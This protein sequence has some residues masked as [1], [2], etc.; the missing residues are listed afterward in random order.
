M[1][2]KDLEISIGAETFKHTL[3][4]TAEPELIMINP[5]TIG[6]SVKITVKSVYTKCKNGGSINIYGTKCMSHAPKDPKKPP[7][8]NPKKDDDPEPEPDPSSC[9]VPPS[10]DKLPKDP[11]IVP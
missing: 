8:P 6:D 7:E 1:R 2:N 10:V 3:R 11:K 4:N 9:D 5:P